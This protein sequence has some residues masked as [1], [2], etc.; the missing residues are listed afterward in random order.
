MDELGGGFSFGN[1]TEAA[2]IPSAF[3]LTI[4]TLAGNQVDWDD[5]NNGI[6]ITLAGK[7]LYHIAWVAAYHYGCS[8]ADAIMLF[9]EPDSR[10][11][12]FTF[13]WT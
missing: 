6:S 8:G 5:P 4:R 11:V 10:T 9:Y 3:E 12:L 2:P 13:D 1:W 7:P